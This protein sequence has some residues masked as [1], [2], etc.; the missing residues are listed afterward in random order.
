MYYERI[1][2][3][4]SGDN[5]NSN[6][7]S[8]DFRKKFNSREPFKI[9]FCSYFVVNFLSSCCCCLIRRQQKDPSSWYS[10]KKRQNEKF[11]IARDKLSSEFDLHNI[12]NLQRIN[13]FIQRM[14]LSKRQRHSV[15]YFRRYTIEDYHLQKEHLR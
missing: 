2:K 14:M 9:S 10:R 12:I 15:D 7:W 8:S 13:C 11:E 6:D 4:S 3:S 5:L 1:Y